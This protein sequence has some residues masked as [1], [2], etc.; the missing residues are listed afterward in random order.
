MGGGKYSRWVGTG[1]GY[2]SGDKTV[3]MAGSTPA[4]K[5]AA[6]TAAIVGWMAGRLRRKDG[7][8]EWTIV[9]EMV[10]RDVTVRTGSD[11]RGRWAGLG[12]A[13][14]DCGDS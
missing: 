5:A 8:N 4:R 7:A 9:G 12:W 11:E 10:G 1:S 2:R 3:S 14:C 13:G 6:M